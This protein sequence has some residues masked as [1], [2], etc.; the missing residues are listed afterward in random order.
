M[1]IILLLINFE[2]DRDCRFDFFACMLLNYFDFC[3]PVAMILFL[4]EKRYFSDALIQTEENILPLKMGNPF[5]LNLS[6][7]P[8]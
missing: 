2:K 6:H 3:K 7:F 8:I 1:R 5:I 4:L